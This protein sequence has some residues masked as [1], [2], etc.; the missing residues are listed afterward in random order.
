M[1]RAEFYGH[2]DDT[3]ACYGNVERDNCAN[4]RPVEM[5]V[6]VGGQPRLRVIGQ[7]AP[8][9]DPHNAATWAITVQPAIDEGAFEGLEMSIGAADSDYSPKLVVEGPD[10]MTVELVPDDE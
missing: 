9:H 3:F 4:R 6:L 5:T 1:K 10:D 2:S 7:Y 8:E